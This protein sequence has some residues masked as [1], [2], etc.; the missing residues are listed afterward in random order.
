MS[1][2]VGFN[3][4]RNLH[5]ISICASHPL[6][7]VTHAPTR[8]TMCG[9]GLA[10]WSSF[11]VVDVYDAAAADAAAAATRRLSRMLSATH[12]FKYI[13]IPGSLM[14]YVLYCACA[15]S[16]LA[17]ASASPPHIPRHA[18]PGHKDTY[19]VYTRRGDPLSSAQ[20]HAVRAYWLV[21][22]HAHAA[23]WQMC[24]RSIHTCC[25]ITAYMYS[26]H[27]VYS[28]LC[29]IWGWTILLPLSE[30]RRIDVWNNPLVLLLLLLLRVVYNRLRGVAAA[31]FRWFV[32]NEQEPNQTYAQSFQL[33]QCSGHFF[34][35][36]FVHSHVS[37][38]L[39]ISAF[40]YNT[41]YNYSRYLGLLCLCALLRVCLWGHAHSCAYQQRQR[42]RFAHRLPAGRMT[43]RV[44]RR[45]QFATKRLARLAARPH[46]HTQWSLSAGNPQCGRSAAGGNILYIIMRKYFSYSSNRISSWADGVGH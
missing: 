5:S 37:I 44:S 10:R 2:D 4:I 34:G 3:N 17:S 45:S 1:D 29:C 23:C 16:A 12:Q 14:S 21:H 35:R 24:V 33:L 40:M 39:D 41:T 22:C 32:F 8:R 36:M 26:R 6:V 46:T 18:V 28:T 20:L 42:R 25:G 19:F 31:W 15:L 27:S 9:T 11:V 13:P 30:R 38:W 7:N 43:A